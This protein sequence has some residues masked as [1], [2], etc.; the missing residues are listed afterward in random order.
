[1]SR[2][3]ICIITGS[4][5]EYGHL[6]W[7]MKAIAG[8]KELSLQLVV[9]GMHLSK[10]F[11][12]TYKQIERDGFKISK[13]VPILNYG[14]SPS[15]IAKSVGKACMGLPDVFSDLK[16]DI[17]VI[18]GDRYEMLAAAVTAHILGI[19]I[20]HLHGGETSEGAID[21]AFRHSI[22]KM[23][24]IHFPAA[25]VYR[26]RII[27]LGE[28]PGRVYNFGAPGLD[29]LEHQELL[30]RAQLEK[31]IGFDLSGQF[32]IITFHPVTLEK[33]SPVAQ[34]KELLKAVRE[35]PFKVIFTKANAVAGG[36]EINN[37]ILDF[38][39]GNPKE[40]LLTD[41]LG[42]LKYLSCLKYADLMIGNSS[43]GIVE[44]SSF[45][46]PVVNI[47]DRQKGRLKAK[48]VLDV[49]C[50]G[51]AIARGIRLALS[52]RFRT[53]LR[54]LKNPY[55]RYAGGGISTRIKDILKKVPLEPAL[56]KKAFYNIDLKISKRGK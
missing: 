3:K 38:V 17:L 50:D 47:G 20:V 25:E 11:G 21:E 37:V 1:M 2:R 53:S 42:T 52:R 41:N 51:A 7:L 44:S 56:F 31:A 45:R 40:Y 16:P 39:K 19:P 36:E 5:A 15:G 33:T 34:V 10:D 6:Y 49:A 13:K 27:Q 4:R 12:L 48:N 43:S 32:A 22:T 8:D 14:N 35:F 28:A 9:T 18:C 23:A 46:L 24:Y 55:R 26:Q 29:Q 30:T 54:D